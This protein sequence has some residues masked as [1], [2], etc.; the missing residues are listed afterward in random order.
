MKGGRAGASRI[1]RIGAAS[2]HRISGRVLTS[3]GNVLEGVRVTVAPQH[4]VFT[5]S[6]GSYVLVGLPEG[7]FE[8]TAVREG[9]RFSHPGF[10]NPVTVGPD[11]V[12][13]DFIADPE[14]GENLVTLVPAGSLWR[15][16]D[17]GSDP[18]EAWKGVDF[19]DGA[20]G[21]GLAQLG[22]GDG[23]EATEIASGP[24]ANTKFIT[25]Y[26]R[27]VVVVS[28]PTEYAV[29]HLGLLRDD[30][31][32]VYL[33]G[34]EIFRS[35]MPDGPIGFRTPAA[36]T[37]GSLAEATFYPADVLPLFLRTGTNVLA[38]EVHQQSATS[39]DLSFDLYLTGLRAADLPRG[40]YVN[41]PLPWDSFVAP[42][43]VLLSAAASGGPSTGI[44]RVEFFAGDH[45]LGV[46]QE[47]P[48]SLIWSQV[49]FGHYDLWAAAA[50]T[51][52]ERMTSSPVSIQVQTR[53]IAAGST[54]NYLD[55]GTDLGRA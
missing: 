44:A 20:W 27:H 10:A 30:G 50:D 24:S 51:Q 17:D 47:P 11:A 1:V 38:V 4:T 8:V 21:V 18:G 16:L 22:Y 15:Y 7:E 31:A 43:D 23:D 37:V 33:N 14:P 34:R 54:W 39:S 5:D 9:Y 40:V 46:V 35:N 49:P 52:G 13:I 28:D 19:D 55:T 36:S 29:L 48:Y 12:D 6:D 42:A 26:F 41:S 2:T 45:S 25:S 32:V 3:R 53:L